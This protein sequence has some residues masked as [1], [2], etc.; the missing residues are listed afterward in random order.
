M[1]VTV[2]ETI[3]RLSAGILLQTIYHANPMACPGEHYCRSN[4]LPLVDRDFTFVLPLFLQ[5]ERDSEP[6][7]DWTRIVRFTVIL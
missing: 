7:I 3:E 2:T 6:F 5:G 1:L 4:N